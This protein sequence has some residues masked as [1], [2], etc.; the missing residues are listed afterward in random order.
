LYYPISVRVQD[1]LGAGFTATPTQGCYELA[2][3]FQPTIVGS[4]SHYRWTFGDGSTDNAANPLHVYHHAGSY[5]VS[6]TVWNA[7]SSDS[8]LLQQLVVVEDC[9]EFLHFYPNPSD[10]LLRLDYFVRGHSGF[11]LQVTD[12]LGQQLQLYDLPFGY[13]A[14][15]L[16]M[17]G[18]AVGTYFATF[19]WPSGKVETRKFVV[20][21]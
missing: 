7:E 9:G 18:L 13:Q 4:A 2:V 10:G 11:R 12:M 20:M 8:I 17:T 1:C 5:N 21:R 3:Q 15:Q 14:H 19:T 16:D 6:L